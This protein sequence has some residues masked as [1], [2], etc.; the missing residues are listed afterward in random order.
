MHIEPQCQSN[1]GHSGMISAS[2]THLVRDRRQEAP[3]W[4]ATP[5]APR[6]SGGP[7]HPRS[8]PVG[9]RRR[10]PRELLLASN[11]LGLGL[12]L[13]LR[14]SHRRPWH[15]EIVEPRHMRVRSLFVR[16]RGYGDECVG[17]VR[18]TNAHVEREALVVL[19]ADWF[20]LVWSHFGCLGKGP[21]RP[22]RDLCGQLRV[23]HANGTNLLVKLCAVYGLRLTH[24]ANSLSKTFS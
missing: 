2:G 24:Y 8:A 6:M 17:I 7:N 9:E 4:A 21:P 11:C 19:I 5:L 15:I 23:T 13:A 14:H 3:P 22:A 1:L 12:G 18:G 10:S 20:D 16:M